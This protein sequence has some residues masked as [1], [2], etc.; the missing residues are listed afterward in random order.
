MF[1]VSGIQDHTQCLEMVGGEETAERPNTGVPSAQPLSAPPGSPEFIST[2]VTR[3]GPAPPAP[4]GS[5]SVPHSDTTASFSLPVIL[6]APLLSLHGSSLVSLSPEPVWFSVFGCCA[7]ILRLGSAPSLSSPRP[8]PRFSNPSS[9]GLALHAPIGWS[10]A[11]S[12]PA[13]QVPLRALHSHKVW[14]RSCGGR[15]RPGPAQLCPPRPDPGPGPQTS[16]YLIQAPV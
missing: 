5:R 7:L 11:P 1:C 10:G 4:A 15:G 8:L 13:H 12:R 14:L 6:P 16:P 3:P 9:A 2:S